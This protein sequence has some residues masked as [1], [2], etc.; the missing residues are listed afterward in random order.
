M[1]KIKFTLAT[2]VISILLTGCW[3]FFVPLEQKRKFTYCYDNSYTGLDT[4]L[5]IDGYFFMCGSSS[6]D[7]RFNHN[8]KFFPNGMYVSNGGSWGIYKF[9]G[10]TIKIQEID[11]PGSRSRTTSQTWFKIRSRDTIQM[12]YSGTKGYSLYTSFFV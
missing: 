2:L 3:I 11:I 5:N 9:F 8:C 6:V 12:I 1:G 10:D 4:I 7:L